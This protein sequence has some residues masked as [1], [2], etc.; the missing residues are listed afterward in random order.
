MTDN[1][2]ENRNPL[3]LSA[4]RT[5]PLRDAAYTYPATQ[6][7]PAAKGAKKAKKAGAQSADRDE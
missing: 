4:A 2:H 6:T 7:E 1:H 3:D 5:D